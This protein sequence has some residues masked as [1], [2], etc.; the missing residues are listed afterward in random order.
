MGLIVLILWCCMYADGQYTRAQEYFRETTSES[1]GDA[2]S[3]L[4][5]TVKLLRVLLED[6]PQPDNYIDESVLYVMD[7]AA[8]AMNT[9]TDMTQVM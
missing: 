2:F 6:I 9:L 8:Q 4:L 1:D 7:V 3:T 5:D